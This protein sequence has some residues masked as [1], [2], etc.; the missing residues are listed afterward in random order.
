MLAVIERHCSVF[1]F[2]FWYLDMAFPT[3]ATLPPSSVGWAFLWWEQ[4]SLGTTASW[5]C[6]T[7]NPSSLC[8]GWVSVLT[9]I[10]QNEFKKH[11]PTYFFLH[12]RL[13]VFWRALWCLKE[14]SYSNE[15]TDQIRYCSAACSQTSVSFSATL[16]VAI[17]EI[18]RSARQQ[19]L[20]FYEYGTYRSVH[21]CLYTWRYNLFQ[22]NVANMCSFC[23]GLQC[24]NCKNESILSQH[25]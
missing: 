14:V 9:Q 3:C 25:E 20:S 21:I 18:K 19:G 8:Y 17:N 24:P 4:A 7:R 23:L 16:L 5:D 13:T 6:C 2:L 11:F 15:P 1:A 12:C 10:I 22:V